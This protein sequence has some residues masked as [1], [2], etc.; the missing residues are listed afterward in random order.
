MFFGQLTLHGPC[1]VL[2]DANKIPYQNGCNPCD[3]KYFRAIVPTPSPAVHT[4]TPTQS[5]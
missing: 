3:R 5:V 4:P 1:G 2:H